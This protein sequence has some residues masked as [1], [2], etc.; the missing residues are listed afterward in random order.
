[1]KTPIVPG[2]ASI[3][4]R[5]W[6]LAV[7]HNCLADP[8]HTFEVVFEPTSWH[9][10]RSRAESR[11]GHLA[12]FTSEGE[13]WEMV[14]Q[15]GKEPQVAVWIGATNEGKDG[16]WRWITGEHWAYTRWSIGQPDNNGGVER[17]G[18]IWP[19]PAGG[20]AG[21]GW[22]DYFAADESPEVRVPGFV[23]EYDRVPIP[24][25]ASGVATIVNGFVVGIGLV[26]AGYGY[27]NAPRVRIIGGGGS[28]T[29]A[30][31]IFESGRLT[32]I[33]VV[34]AGSGYTSAPVIEIDAPQFP[35]RRAEGIADVVNGFVV[36]VRI[37]DA[38]RAYESAPAVVLVGGGGT[39]AM[40]TATVLNG[41]VTGVTIT[42]PGTGYITSPIVRIASP[43]FSPSLKVAV[44]KVSVELRVVLGRKYLLEASTDL[45]DWSPAGEAFV[46]E[47]ETLVRELDAQTGGRY[48]RIMGV[49]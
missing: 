4:T 21:F 3:L 13:Y 16:Q 28:G 6:L 26:D 19:I 40:A 33:T 46:A 39:G 41:V 2:L 32:G 29:R 24:R 45:L 18:M 14:L 44:S 48:F 31:A 8:V 22:N 25:T 34:S 9:E 20:Q 30:D 37:T 5:L 17:Y 11:G 47:D 43:Q 35:P 49:P 7:V 36:G 42:A 27:T 1:M 23:V 10:A 38:G 15:V 12:T